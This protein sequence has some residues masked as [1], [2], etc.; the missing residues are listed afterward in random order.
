[1]AG[2]GISEETISAFKI[3]IAPKGWEI[4]KKHLVG[5]GN[6]EADINDAGLTVNRGEGQ[7]GSYDRFR[8]RLMF[9]INDVDGKTVGFGARSLDGS[10]PKYMNSPQNK[11]FDKSASL[12]GMDRAK[13]SLESGEPL[14]LVE[15]Y[16]DVIQAHQSGFTNVAAIMGTS[17]VRK[18][19]NLAEKYTKKYILALDSDTAGAEATRRSLE[20]AWDLFNSEIIRLRGISAPVNV[21]REIPNLRI[22]HLGTSKDPDEV[23]KEN[24]ETWKS[25]VSDAEPL[26][27]YLISWEVGQQDS[28]D[29]EGKLA[30]VERIFP[31]IGRLDNPFEQ[32]AAFSKL[33]RALGETERTLEI[34]AGRPPSKGRRASPKRTTQESDKG[35]NFFE[36]DPTED[37]L[38]G[39]VLVYG[40]KAW[41]LW[42]KL[43]I[44]ALPSECFINPE[45][46]ELWKILTSGQPVEEAEAIVSGLA[47]Q[48]RSKLVIELDE[49]ALGRALGDMVKRLLERQIKSQ[50][51]E[52]ALAISSSLEED[53]VANLVP[54]EDI[55]SQFVNRIEQLRKLERSRWGRPLGGA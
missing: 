41:A 6:K 51:E 46:A 43:G 40:E 19:L 34:A 3:G 38:L 16:M 13:D 8:D 18:Q 25:I 48:L 14:V 44:P 2:R 29:S 7:E 50:E 35:A 39:I 5:L 10:E 53:G 27:D 15:G 37:H 31:L 22:A 30:I 21:K 4:L 1:L 45:N 49:N 12:Y 11:I 9:P 42:E 36:G 20:N 55:R 26:L 47:E 52:A 24:P 28:L 23:I 32:E 33:A 54:P 17:L